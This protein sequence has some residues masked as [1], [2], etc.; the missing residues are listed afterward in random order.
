MLALYPTAPDLAGGER[1]Q[2]ACETALGAT[3]LG[4]V[5]AAPASA[6]S[7]IDADFDLAVAILE[8]LKIGLAEGGAFDTARVLAIWN[9]CFELLGRAMKG[10]TDLDAWLLYS[11]L[12]ALAVLVAEAAPMS[13]LAR[14]LLAS[15]VAAVEENPGLAVPV[16]CDLSSPFDALR[17]ALTHERDLLGRLERAV[18]PAMGCTLGR[19]APR[20]GG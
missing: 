2:L 16:R 19:Y 11:S 17:A 4:P 14:A 18:A 3:G 7:A 9:G 20:G 13:E 5:A 6:G 15:T 12:G 10:A 8:R 1:A